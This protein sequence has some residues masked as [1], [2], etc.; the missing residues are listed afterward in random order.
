MRVVI[1]VLVVAIIL[2]L[3]TA[4][5]RA[6]SGKAT[7]KPRQPESFA[8]CAHCGVHLPLNDA[9]VDRGI[10]FCSEAHRLAGPR[11]HGGS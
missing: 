11:D 6:R 9:L 10:A 4:R 1:V 3:L 8:R 2:W 5:S 7:P